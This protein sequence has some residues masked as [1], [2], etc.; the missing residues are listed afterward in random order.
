M[1]QGGRPET[2]PVHRVSLVV[3]VGTATAAV[4]GRCSL[5]VR[6]LHHRRGL[7]EVAV[8]ALVVV[9]VVLT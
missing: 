9:V 1:A 7:L 5:V 6:G 8:L 3:V 2:A 4:P